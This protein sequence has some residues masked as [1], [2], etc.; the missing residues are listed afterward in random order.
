MLPPAVVRKANWRHVHF[1]RA[2]ALR[3][4]HREIPK[5]LVKNKWIEDMGRGNTCL[6]RNH[7]FEVE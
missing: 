4:M 6:W 5:F 7:V 2:K 1:P 3:K